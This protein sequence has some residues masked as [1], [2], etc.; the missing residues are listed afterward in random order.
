VLCVPKTD[1]EMHCESCLHF[2]IRNRYGYLN[3]LL[4]YGGLEPPGLT[5]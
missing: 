1:Y 3:P 4:F 5:R 2:S